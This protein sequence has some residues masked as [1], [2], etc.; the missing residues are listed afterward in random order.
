MSARSII[1]VGAGI[2]GS[3]VAY[4][5]AGLGHQVTVLEQGVVG[6]GTTH[7]AAGMVARLRSSRLLTDITVASARLYARLEAENGVSTGWVGSGSLLLAP[8]ED[9]W[10]AFRRQAALARL[11]GIEVELLSASDAARHWPGIRTDDLVGA[12][13]IPGDGKVDPLAAARSLAAGARGRGAIVEEGRRVT[14]LVRDDARVTG[15]EVDGEERP[16]SADAVVLAGGMWSRQLAGAIGVP[17]ALHPVEH[18]YVRF[19]PVA[20]VRDDLPCMREYDASLYFRPDRDGL[21]LGAFQ[22]RSKPWAV[23][24]VPDDFSMRLLEPDW[25]AF[26]TPLRAARHRLP[27]LADAPVEQ[28]VNGPESF[29][30][31]GN[32]LLGPAPGIDGLFL[33]AG[34]N[35]L[36]IA[37]GGGAGALAAQWLHDGRPPRDVWPLDPSRF[38]PFQAGRAYLRERVAETLGAHYQIPWPNREMETAR[39]VRRTPLHPETDA[40]GA[41]FGQRSGWERPLR[42]AREGRPRAM[43]YGWGRT[44]SWDDWAAEHRAAREGVAIFDQSTFGKILVDGPDALAG[45]NRVASADLD[46]PVG[47]A[48]YSAMLDDAGRFVSD[49]TFVRTAP[50]TFLAIVSTA[51]QLHDLEWIRRGLAGCRASVVD[52]TARTGVIGIHGPHARDVLARITDADVSPSAA[53]YLSATPIAVGRAEALALRV[54]YVGELGWEL[55][56][57][58]DS[59]SDVFRAVLEAAELPPRSSGPAG[60][61]GAALAGTTAQNSLRLEKSFAAWGGDL[62]GDD[63]PIEARYGFL[64]AWAKAGG[65]VGRDALLRQRDTGVPKS[66]ATFV[67]DDPKPLLWGGE[68]I[69]RDGVPVGELTSGSYGHT[70]GASVGLGYVERRD[71][72]AD[73]AWL[74]AGTY[75]V[76]VDGEIVPASLHLR[77]P[78]DPT[79][80]RMLDLPATEQPDR[81]HGDIA[82]VR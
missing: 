25:P 30:P 10:T 55:H 27:A 35:S 20:D 78:Y 72:V 24:R 44:A 37:Q 63:T 29:T 58:A 75:G 80:S 66:L 11:W 51:Q 82:P 6:G 48:V 65:F 47:R 81:V 23:D 8:N 79:R 69:L 56:V 68:V 76:E 14:A 4:H 49:L 50:T 28:F 57:D 34:F 77:A 73:R 7:H 45:L 32:Y 41:V 53:T 42:Y 18:H 40:R 39:G 16:R 38:L 62:S 33:L 46:V 26:E 61:F 36:G 60:P 52:V 43:T 5:L 22:P 1:V 71:G 12:V 19:R 59:A 54:S 64:C 15:V 31:D 21:W 3:S 70:L 9:R 67:L 17:V 74:T 2:A 13:W